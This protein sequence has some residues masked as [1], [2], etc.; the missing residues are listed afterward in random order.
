MKWKLL[1]R[2]EGIENNNSNFSN[3]KSSNNDIKSIRSN[4]QNSL[5]QWMGIQG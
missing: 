4:C 1:F 2:V 3:R 5:K